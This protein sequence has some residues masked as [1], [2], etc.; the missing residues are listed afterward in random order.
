MPSA[1]THCPE[2]HGARVAALN[3]ILFAPTA[4]FFRCEDCGS[5]WHVQ[6]GQDG[7]ASR[8][9]LGTAVLNSPAGAPVEK[10]AR[11]RVQT[12]TPV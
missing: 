1:R 11:A 4:D 10:P 8:S 3:A 2:C 7:P 12:R 6:K 9:L 5:L